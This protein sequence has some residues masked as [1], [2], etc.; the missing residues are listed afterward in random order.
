MVVA[1]SDF[2][3]HDA[4][5]PDREQMLERVG[6]ALAGVDGIELGYAFGSFA[7]GEPFRDLD[8]AVLLDDARNW[9][10]PARAGRAIWEA[11]GRPGFEIDVVPLNDAS[12]AF[13]R[14]VVTENRL[15]FE[16]HSGSAADFW[17]SAVSEDI[18]FREWKRAHG[19]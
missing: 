7:R 6:R 15:V 14:A 3:L 1:Q 5:R 13:K 8:V 12:P 17:V 18:D 11:L 16:R 4:P 9:R 19:A 2:A 10:T